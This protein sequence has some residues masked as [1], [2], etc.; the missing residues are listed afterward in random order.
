MTSRINWLVFDKFSFE[1]FNKI[2]DFSIDDLISVLSGILFPQF[3]HF[4]NVI[5]IREL[6]SLRLLSFFNC[7]CSNNLNADFIHIS[8]PNSCDT[9]LKTKKKN[10]VNFYF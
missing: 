9:Q 8:I 6:S 7:A 2:S 3:N 5:S 4:P 10:P 1:K